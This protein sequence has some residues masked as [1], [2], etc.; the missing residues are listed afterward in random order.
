MISII[1]PVYNVANYLPQCIRSICGQTYGDLEIVLVDDGSTDGC[2]EICEKYAEKDSRINFIHMKNGGSVAAR[3]QGLSHATG[4]YIAFAD[5]DDWLEP[6]MLER[7]MKILLCEKVDV[8]MCGRFEDTGH[9]CQEVYHGIPAGRYDKKALLDK[10]YPGMIVNGDFFEWGIF[11]GLWDK[12]FRRECLEQFLMGVDDAITMGDDAAGTY[13]CILNADSIYILDKCLY[14]YRQTQTSTVKQKADAAVER[15]RFHIL[16][17]TVL[18]TLN[19]YKDIYDLTNQWKE[20]TLFLMVPRADVLLKGIG[21]LDY[22]FPFPNVKRGSR[23]VIYGM[24]TYGQHLYGYLKR[25]G[26]CTVEAAFDRNY[27][28]L[29]KQGIAAD[30][31]EC[32]P[33]HEFDAIVIACSFAKTRRAIYKE[34][35]EKYGD[36]A[37][38]A[39]D[40]ALIK[41]RAI[42][43]AFGLVCGGDSL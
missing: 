2:Y 11:P 10:V 21:E 37:V 18:R 33:E 5:G 25:S 23:I 34:L 3:K 36:K 7:L 1:V 9:I 30:P 28:E 16:Y 32:I 6:D 24:G 39:M 27:T 19:L 17:E 22:L 35:T 13:P 40:E 43:S 4:E 29:R 20:Y 12:L 8:A 31:P 38:H 42:V 15:R 14:H 41:S 26:F